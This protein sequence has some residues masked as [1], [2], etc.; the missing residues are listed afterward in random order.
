MEDIKALT[1]S[2]AQI[3]EEKGIPFETVIDVIEQALAAAYKKDNDRKGENIRAKL[4]SQTGGVKF[5]QVFEVVDEDMVYSEEE[6]AELKLKAE[7]AGET[8]EEQER[9]EEITDGEEK[10]IRFNSKKHIMLKEAKK[11]EPKIQINDEFLVPLEADTDYGR[12]A[13]QTAKQVILQRLKEAERN[14]VL[15]E[16]KSKEGE[17]VSGVVQRVEGTNVF[18]DIGKALGVLMPAE[19][20]QGENYYVG[21]RLRLYLRSV[22]ATPKGPT[23]VLSRAYPKFVSKLFEIEV[24]EVSSGQVE[25]KSIAREPGFRTKVAVSTNEEGIDPIGAMVGQ[26]GTR[27]M[28]VI[29]SLTGEKIDIILWSDDVEEFIS[30]SL[31]PAKVLEVQ[32]E[33]KGKATVIVAEDQLSLAIGKGGQ[34]VRLAARLT[35]WK[36]DI[37]VEG[38]DKPIEAGEVK[39]EDEEE[40][41]DEPKKEVKEKSE[42]KKAEKKNKETKTKKTKAPKADAKKKE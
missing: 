8:E 28:A 17:V 11:T 1:S 33:E 20:I 31:S 4:D 10:K 25:I 34:N 35:G 9:E 36:I 42:P 29:N 12:I 13:A 24:P 41:K 5:W 2:I 22:E 40:L 37:Q 38:T 39:E 26:R 15:E 18:F 21:Q 27:V 23:I 30:N 6:L 7:E 14:A 32:V 19:Q 3:A 16:Y